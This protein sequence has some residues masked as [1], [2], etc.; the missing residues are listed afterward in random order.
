MLAIVIPYY[1]KNFFKDTLDSL[2]NQTD[3]RFN[4]YVGNDASPEDPL[5]IIEEFR[6]KIGKV[7][8]KKFEF[9]LGGRSLTR[10]W[11]RCLEM[12]EDEKWVMILGDDDLLSEN[13][14]EEFHNQLSDIDHS[15]VNV[16]R[17]ATREIND[18]GIIISKEYHHPKLQDYSDSFYER[19]FN[20]SR[21][22]LSEHIFSRTQFEK[23]GFRN[24]PLAWHSDDL[25]WLEFSEFGKIYTINKAFVYFRLSQIN[26]SRH[27]YR[28][29]EKRN[30]R[31]LFFTIVVNE[32]IGN[33]KKEHIHNILKRYELMTYS[34]NKGNV[35]FYK[36]FFPLIMKYFGV[37]ESLKFTRR[38]LLNYGRDK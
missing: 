22:S 27:G 4:L 33:F 10:Q 11:E 31:F 28:L 12:V 37:W 14:V 18:Q 5:E 9:N 23:Y 26:I 6:R 21:S 38:I 7:V 20:R 8:Y 25:A 29:E 19:F 36:R 3:K 15:E 16:I 17:F 34:L 2:A 24:L 32:Y 30:G 13:V 1:K 35:V